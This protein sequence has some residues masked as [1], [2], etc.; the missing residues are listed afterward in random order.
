MESRNQNDRPL[1]H[2]WQVHR[3]QPTPRQ[4]V[5]YKHVVVG[6]AQLVIRLE[7]SSKALESKVTHSQNNYNIYTQIL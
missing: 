5:Y 6:V 4:A 2:R 7:S 1:L 3:I